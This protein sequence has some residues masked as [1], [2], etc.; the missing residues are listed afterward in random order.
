MKLIRVMCLVAGGI[1]CAIIMALA[2]SPRP[3]L[4][5]DVPFGRI[6]LAS[7]GDILRL[8]LAGDDRYRFRV[9]LDEV[10]EEAI[11]AILHYED[12]RFYYHPG[13]DVCSMLKAACG[14]VCG[15]GRKMGASTITM[16][17]ARLKYKIH[18][19]TFGGKLRQIWSAMVLERHYSKAEILEAYFNLAPYGGNIEGIEAAARVYFRK[20]ASGLTGSECR[21]LAVVPQNP[22]LRNPASGRQFNEARLRLEESL[23]N[24][25][26][27]P[28][29]V[30]AP[31]SVPFGAP[32]FAN[33]V[34]SRFPEAVI[35]TTIEPGLQR[36]LENSIAGYVERNRRYGIANAAAILVETSSMAARALAGSASFFNSRILGQVDGTS[37]RRSPG[38]TLKPFI[39]ALALEQG[40]IHPQT[41]LPDSPRSFGGYDPENFDRMFR[42]PVCAKEALQASRNLPAIMLAEKLRHPGMYGFLNSAGISFPHPAEY[43]GLALALGGAEINMRQ[44]AELYAMLANMGL[45]QPIRYAQ[46]QNFSQPR[47]LLLPEA[48][49]LALAMLERDGEEYPSYGKRIPARYKTGTSNGLRDAWTAGIVGDYVLVVWVGNF[50]GTP[51]PLFIGARTALPLFSE[52]ALGIAS[53]RPLQDQQ[54]GVRRKLNIKNVRVCATTGD[55]ELDHCPEVVETMFIPGV[56]PIK[57]SNIL[58]PVL[59]DPKTGLRACA[60]VPGAEEVW[61]EFWPTEMAAIFAQAGVY[62]PVPPPWLAQCQ[63]KYPS[64]G[65]GPEILLPKK[66][67]IYRRSLSDK[68]WKLPLKASC[69]ADAEAVHWYAGHDYVGQSAPG[70]IFLWSPSDAGNIIISAVDNL[71]RSASRSC[72]IEITP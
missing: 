33:D 7:N 64:V 26:S 17:V 21:A 59:I 51:N 13:L 71:G 2:V 8:C 19:R 41:I 65:H 9:S 35:R 43:Y 66:N 3:P 72:R 22:A 5:E 30:Y 14:L 36:Y 50:D 29:R 44:L 63:D 37:A 54:E 42:G 1:L 24:S 58:R 70:E 45:W 38:S 56:S 69:E 34:I 12:R 20:A 31:S 23:G 18:T 39:Y 61:Y 67:V 11:R 49:T 25:S 46:N 60:G 15:S 62:K 55:F 47:R 27:G 28:L 10:P 68:S 53:S 16:Q 52:L 48:A 32:H 4:L 40:L 6:V 57:S